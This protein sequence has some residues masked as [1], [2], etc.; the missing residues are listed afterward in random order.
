MFPLNHSFEMKMDRAPIKGCAGYNLLNADRDGGDVHDLIK[1]ADVCWVSLRERQRA[2]LIQMS[3]HSGI[4]AE[5]IRCVR[6]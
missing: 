4:A 3:Y 1:V 5:N 2:G 6:R